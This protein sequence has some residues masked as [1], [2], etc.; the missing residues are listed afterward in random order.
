[1]SSQVIASQ[2][3]PKPTSPS[4]QRTPIPDGPLVLPDN[5]G[6][7]AWNICP[8]DLTVVND[9]RMGSPGV[10]CANYLLHLLIFGS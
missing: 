2:P 9:W 8:G 5:P 7:E 1:M 3:A 6:H 4:H 10:S